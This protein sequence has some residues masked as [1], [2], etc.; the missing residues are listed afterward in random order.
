[1]KK[2][3]SFPFYKAICLLSVCCLFVPLALDAW[4]TGCP[5]GA[6]SLSA[7]LLCGSALLLLLPVSE[8][9]PVGSFRFALAACAVC[10]SV[11]VAGLPPRSRVLCILPIPAVYIGYR[12]AGRYVQLWHLFKP[13]KVWSQVEWHARDSYGLALVLLAAFFPGGAAPPAA[14]W[15]FVLPCAVL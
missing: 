12:G 8:E 9:K 5:P 7:T 1:M 2:K 3:S 10:L 6:D 14:H 13:T 4:R 15:I 11:A